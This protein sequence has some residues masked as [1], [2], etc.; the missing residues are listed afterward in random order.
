MDLASAPSLTNRSP[1]G[2]SAA[3]D[4]LADDQIQRLMRRNAELE[5]AL[6][7]ERER[8]RHIEEKVR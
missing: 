6:E 4:V 8:R 2:Q 7:Q 3:T 1:T 5:Q